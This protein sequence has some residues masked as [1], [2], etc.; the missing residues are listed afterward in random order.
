MSLFEIVMLSF[1]T[2]PLSVPTDIGSLYFF[3]WVP[4]RW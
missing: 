2:V 1:A 3:T 4:L